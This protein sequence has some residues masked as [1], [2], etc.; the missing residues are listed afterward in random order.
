VNNFF[1][2]S[3]QCFYRFWYVQRTQNSRNH[4]TN[5]HFFDP[6]TTHLPRSTYLSK[7]CAF[8]WLRYSGMLWNSFLLQPGAS[9]VKYLQNLHLRTHY[10]RASSPT[11]F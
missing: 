11:T 4:T 1:S 5:Q 7:H 8:G 6:K 2:T 10:V 9:L 3:K